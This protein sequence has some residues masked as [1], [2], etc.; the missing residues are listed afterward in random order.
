[1]TPEVPRFIIVAVEVGAGEFV[2]LARHA[3]PLGQGVEAEAT[4]C[5]T[6]RPAGGW[7]TAGYT[8]LTETLSCLACRQQA[9]AAVPGLRQVVWSAHS[10]PRSPTG[11]L[12]AQGHTTPG[13]PRP[14]PVRMITR[15]VGWPWRPRLVRLSD[16]W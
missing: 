12:G 8:T 9:N 1:M 5:D 7:T 3:L 13:D 15:Y 4:L 14:L 10:P 2:R 6:P 11:R 16:Q